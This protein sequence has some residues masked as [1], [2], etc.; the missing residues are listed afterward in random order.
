MG[1]TLEDFINLRE[2]TAIKY[3]FFN[4]SVSAD[5]SKLIKEIY[6]KLFPWY[7]INPNEY[8][9]DTMNTYKRAI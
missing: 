8:A 4:E 6:A 9:G 2:E 3:D 5:N 7:R 1:L